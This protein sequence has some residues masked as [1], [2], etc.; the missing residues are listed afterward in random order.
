VRATVAES[1][2]GSRWARRW[3]IFR[4]EIQRWQDSVILDADEAVERPCRLTNES[5][6]A[7]RPL[8]LVPCQ[9]SK[10]CPNGGTAGRHSEAAR[11]PS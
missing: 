3:R 1:P 4:Y 2:A 8:D 7:Q 5:L 6:A 9:R 11:A 10:Y